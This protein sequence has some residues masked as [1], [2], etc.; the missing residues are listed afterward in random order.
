M[1]EFKENPWTMSKTELFSHIRHLLH[2][3]KFVASGWFHG[4]KSGSDLV[5]CVMEHWSSNP[6]FNDTEITAIVRGCHETYCPEAGGNVLEDHYYL[7]TVMLSAHI[8]DMLNELADFDA[9]WLFADEGGRI[10]F[11]IGKLDNSSW[12]LVKV[13]HEKKLDQSIFTYSEI[14][15]KETT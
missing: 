3:H 12:E 7:D 9:D 5:E 2:M 6:D 10:Y 14:D 13:T 15:T 11:N 1:Q 4:D 8:E